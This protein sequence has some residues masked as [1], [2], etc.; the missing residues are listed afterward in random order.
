M[1]QRQERTDT[2]IRMVMRPADGTPSDAFAVLEDGRVVIISGADYSARVI[3]PD[4][5]ERR[6]APLPTLR[7]PITDAMRRASID[8]TAKMAEVM[9]GFM[10]QTMKRLMAQMGDIPPEAL[11]MMPKLIVAIDTVTPFPELLPPLTG[12]QATSGDRLWISVPGDLLGNVAHIDVVRADGT[13][14]GRVRPPEGEQI[15]SVSATAVYTR[16]PPGPST[17]LRRYDLPAALR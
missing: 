7:R 3:A 14:L 9:R 5:S 4:G 10:D 1:R 8:S 17:Q 11:A 2:E 16:T 6:L 12:V 13:L 15:I